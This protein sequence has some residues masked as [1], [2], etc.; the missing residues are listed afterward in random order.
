MLVSAVLAAA[1]PVLLVLV[2]LLLAAVRERRAPCRPRLHCAWRFLQDR[3]V[4]V[5]PP[6]AR[7]ATDRS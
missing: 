5:G 6:A 7:R 1:A 2:A 3:A 4:A